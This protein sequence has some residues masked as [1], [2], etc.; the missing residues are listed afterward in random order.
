M[1]YTC[2]LKEILRLDKDTEF[3]NNAVLKKLKT[4]KPGKVESKRIG[5]CMS[6][7]Y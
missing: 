7:N 2:Q 6:G 3:A 4:P 1:N 5:W